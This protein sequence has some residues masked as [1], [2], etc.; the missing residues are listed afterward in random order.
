MQPVPGLGR[1]KFT[2]R[3][4]LEGARPVLRTEP[5][6]PTGAGGRTPAQCAG[7][8]HWVMWMQ[9]C[10]RTLGS[11]PTQGQAGRGCVQVAF[12]LPAAQHEAPA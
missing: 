9:P 4:W 10:L 12:P 8:A 3:D 11:P 7:H 1:L 2:Q 6:I 5:G